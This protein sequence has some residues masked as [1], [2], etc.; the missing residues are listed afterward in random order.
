MARCFLRQTR[1]SNMITPELIGKIIVSSIHLFSEQPNILDDTDETTTTEWDDGHH[2]AN[3]LAR[4][5]FWLDHDLHV[6]KGNNGNKRDSDQRRRR[7][8]ISSKR[9]DMSVND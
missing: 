9:K 6:V 5:I 1:G 7:T 3:V 4:H 8:I 2:F